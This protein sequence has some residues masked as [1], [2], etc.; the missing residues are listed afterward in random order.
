[1]CIRDSSTTTYCVTVSDINGCLASDCMQVFVG[2]SFGAV[3]CEDKTICRNGNIQ[4]TVTSG[5]AY[6]WSPATGLSNTTIGTPI[7]SPTQTT[8]YTVIV[9]DEAGCTSEDQVVVNVDPTCTG[10]REC[11][12]DILPEA[13]I[14]INLT[15]CQLAA[16]LLS[17]IHI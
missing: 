12:E 15:D 16:E 2:N 8:T 7:A 3:A 4:L 10:G 9:T 17:L 14:E 1:M 13:Q 11:P 6:Q 5:A